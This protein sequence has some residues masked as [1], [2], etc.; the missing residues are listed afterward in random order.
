MNLLTYLS[1]TLA[2]VTSTT[3]ASLGIETTHSTDCTRRTQ[4]GDN[5]HMHYRGT[6][7]S[8]KKEFD[9]SY[10]RGEPLVFPVGEGIVIRG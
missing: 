9:S 10:K 8:T 6:L 7:A 2:V 4:A 5:I 3:A 1:L